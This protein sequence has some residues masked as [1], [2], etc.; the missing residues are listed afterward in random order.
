METK[1]RCEHCGSRQRRDVDWGKVVVRVFQVVFA[2]VAL[3]AVFAAGWT[4]S[5]GDWN[6]LWGAPLIAGLCVFV[7]WML[8]GL[9]EW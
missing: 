4:A 6:G 7:A 8:E 1:W 3:G 5:R 2:I 9:A